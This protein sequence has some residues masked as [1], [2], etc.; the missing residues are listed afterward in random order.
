MADYVSESWQ[1]ALELNQL[2]SF[3]ALWQLQAEWFEAPNQ[4]R[5][6]WSGVARYELPKTDGQARVIFLKRQENHK[7]F[8]WRHPIAGV[9]TFLREFQ[10]I[11]HYRACGVPTLEP[12]YFA[13]RRT[14]A[15]HR[16]ILATAELTGY[17]SLE[18]RLRQWQEQGAPAVSVR[19]RLIG[20]I[21]A[22]ARTLHA[23][24]IQ[25]NCFYPKHLFVRI[26]SDGDSDVRVIDL[27]KS[28]WRPLAMFCTLRDLD[29]LNRHARGVSR[30]DRLR[31]LK[32]YLQAEG[33]NPRLRKLWHQLAARMSKKH[34]SGA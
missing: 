5:G 9:P 12:V 8:S 14:S 28:R 19:R 10:H 24:K 1:R 13:M 6:G 20:K 27:E 33:T 15:G 2:N 21:A 32:A 7:I 30:T 25:H 4:R 23:H 22:L 3:D 11:E 31:F 26:S 17:A 29:T 18:D 34:R 16:A